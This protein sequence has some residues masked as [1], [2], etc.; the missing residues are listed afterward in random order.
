MLAKRSLAALLV[1]SVLLLSGCPE[2]APKPPG[3]G[4]SGKAPAGQPADGPEAPPPAD[5]QGASGRGDGGGNGAPEG[6]AAA[7]DAPADWQVISSEVQGKDLYPMLLPLATWP[8]PAGLR[9]IEQVPADQRPDRMRV[10]LLKELVTLVVHEDLRP[11]DLDAALGVDDA[12]RLFLRLGRSKAEGSASLEVGP[13]EGR[14]KFPILALTLAQKAEGPQTL[15]QL[16]A[17]VAKVVVPELAQELTREK[18]RLE[19]H[20]QVQGST[21]AGM[22]MLDRAGFGAQFPYLYAYATNEHL[23]VLLQEVPHAS[24][25]EGR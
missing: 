3:G 19:A 12:G 21:T 20:P 8:A 13:E 16:R 9:A 1:T 15:D 5:G 10:R 6:A 14:R 7:G 2:P 11:R 17:R 23:T 25:D 18:H 22:A 4:G 24:L